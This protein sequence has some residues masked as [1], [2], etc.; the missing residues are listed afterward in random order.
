MAG[1]A[2]FAS[3][4]GS[5][6]EAICLALRD[7]PHRV[8]RLFYDR[9]AAYARERAE[10]LGV[11][12]TYVPYQGR[13]RSEAEAEAL[14]A[15]ASEGVRLV[16]LAGFM[17]LLGPDFLSGFPGRVV[18]IHPSLLPAYPGVDSIRRAFEAGEEDFGITIHFVDEGM[19]TGPRIIQ[20]SFKRAPGEGL[21][22]IEAR[23]HALEHIWYPRVL[24]G[25]LD[26][27][28]RL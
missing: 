25:L 17:R 16:A 12:A 4:S 26:E 23:V 24:A 2:V 10:R 21:D 18:N 7:G 14:R 20:R 5:N 22:S 27:E 6:F 19:D 3:G 1:L 13:P 11:P 15:L 28:D 9:K 8:A